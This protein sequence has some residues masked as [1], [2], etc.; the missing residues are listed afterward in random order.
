MIN[1]IKSGAI[2]FAAVLMAASA[3]GGERRPAALT[4]SGEEIKA[5][6]FDVTARHRIVARQFPAD[7]GGLPVSEYG[8]FAV[9]AILDT[10]KGFADEALWKTPETCAEVER[11]LD[12]GGRIVV[13]GQAIGELA[14]LCPEAKRIVNSSRVDRENVVIWRLRIKYAAA[15]KPL[16]VTLDRG[17]YQLTPEGEEV[18]ELDA[19]YARLIMSAKDLDLSAEPNE[20]EPK[21]LGEP[22]HLKVD[23]SLPNK[24]ALRHE[25]PKSS[26]GLLL[27]DG[28]TR[29]EIVAPRGDAKLTALA[30]ELAWHF[31]KMTGASF[32]V[33]EKPSS[34][35]TPAIVLFKDEK[36]LGHTVVRTRGNRLELGGGL[37]G[38]SHAVT[39]LLESLGCRYLW[40][41]KLGKVIPKRDRL[42]APDVD[43]D[44][45][46]V[47][48]V[49]ELRDYRGMNNK[50]R[51]HPGN[52]GF[53]SWHGVSNERDL[54]GAYRWGHYFA[55]YYQRYFKD[56]PD[57]FALQPNGSRE[58]D[59]SERP[60]RPQLCLSSWGLAYQ[61]AS[62]IVEVFRRSPNMRA[63]S[64]C[65]PDGGSP[66][67]CMCRSCRLLDPVNAPPARF[68]VTE[69]WHRYFDYV[70]FSDR[71]MTFNNRVAEL[72]TKEV[73]YAKLTCYLYSNYVT[74]PCKVRPHPAMILITDCGNYVDAKRFDWA[75]DNIGACGKYGNMF[76]WGTC[77]LW[78]FRCA[79]PQNFSRRLFEDMEAF[80]ANGLQ[81]I[82]F[83][84]QYDRWASYGMVY[85]VA[86]KAQLNLE[87]VDYD[88]LLDDYCEKGFG[89][90]APAVKRYYLALEEVQE[91]A[92]RA[93]NPIV[94]Y[95]Q[96]LD[97]DRFE[98][99]LSDGERL[100]SGDEEVTARLRFMKKIWPFARL[101]KKVVTSWE[102]KTNAVIRAAQAEAKAYR[103]SIEEDPLVYRHQDF[104]RSFH[105]PYHRAPRFTN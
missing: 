80:K 97:A 39:Y 74:P 18:S 91:K 10:T 27:Y 4:G 26:R 68:R 102:T 85:Y 45:V 99:I 86:A 36:S 93:E 21:P 63:H 42:V 43:L 52:R 100:A 79:V 31:Q 60:D 51:D 104:D 46:A 13:S 78:G 54:D 30:K 95:V 105:S 50:F 47:L 38:A 64:V 53:F 71:V 23:T 57:W 87:R 2:S 98:G 19:R 44:D 9:V 92:A 72:V 25:F 29:A 1:L 66:S 28:K 15:G 48:K 8:K 32:D 35:D 24:P 34:A 76:F 11:Y 69:P 5:V 22:G 41:G 3:F 37:Y 89:K 61:T 101:E 56:H 75:R 94:A 55:D 70:S 103:D 14:A 88:A 82:D 33:V 7:K 20:W 96:G 73:P 59:L 81:G 77:A 16:G 65:M 40:P 67:E 6:V 90:A 49:R 83:D 84:C 12:G 58:Q 17:E 62:N